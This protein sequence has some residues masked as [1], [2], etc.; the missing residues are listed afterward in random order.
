MKKQ[1]L[2]NNNIN[3][4]LIETVN[5][6]EII[7]LNPHHLQSLCNY[8]KNKKEINYEK[9]Y[10]KEF[11]INIENILKKILSCNVFIVNG[12]DDI[13]NYCHYR[14][15]GADCDDFEGNYFLDLYNVKI[16]KEYNGKYIFEL[17]IY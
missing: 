8:L 12:K 2:S 3:P 4:L 9:E 14:L 11:I 6:S 7:R 17:L 1:I 5:L 10:G 13:C 16:N 15:K